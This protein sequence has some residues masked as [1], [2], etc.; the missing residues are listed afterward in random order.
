MSDITTAVEKI[1]QARALLKRTEATL[2]PTYG[3]ALRHAIV[4][5]D[6]LEDCERQRNDALMMA[7]SARAEV[8]RLQAT[9]ESE[10][11]RA[12]RLED[13]N[14]RLAAELA[15]VQAENVAYIE[16]LEA[17]SRAYDG[18]RVLLD[19]VSRSTVEGAAEH[20]KAE[21]RADRAE[22]ILRGLRAWLEDM[23]HRIGHETTPHMVLAKLTELEANQ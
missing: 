17:M 9:I 18:A 13:D 3:A 12:N 5:V 8:E 20:V 19:T 14:K 2:H 16:A 7:A 10:N 21:A 15:E 23:G 1:K 11:M 22:A 6:A 4:L